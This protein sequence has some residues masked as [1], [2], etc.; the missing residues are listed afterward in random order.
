MGF[1]ITPEIIEI[2]LPVLGKVKVKELTVGEVFASQN[3]KE[4]DQIFYLVGKSLVEPKVTE[5][6]L[7]SLPTKCMED[8][9]TIVETVTG[10]SIE[11]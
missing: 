3:L 8:L 6:E 10:G 7:K 4:Q 1:K 5:N 2:N 11:K 9:A